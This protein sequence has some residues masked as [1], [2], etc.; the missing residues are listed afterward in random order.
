MPFPLPLPMRR[1]LDLAAQA[2]ASGEVP[3][4]AVI[5]RGEEIIAT[6]ANMMLAGNDPT[7]HAEIVAIRRAA[8]SL[9]Q[10]RLDG[11]D[12]WVTLE[13]CT[14]CA[15]AIAHAR[16]ARLYYAADDPKGGA[17]AHGPRFFQQPT[18]HHRPEVYPGI[19][20]EEAARQLRGFFAERR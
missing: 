19:G 18:C 3:V 13:P 16:I 1:A 20:A 17:V 8:E 7:A 4:G 15:G 9:G 11:L 5:A 2:A 6:S 14:M 12:L 10:S